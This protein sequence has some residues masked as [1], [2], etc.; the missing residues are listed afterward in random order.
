MG[1]V[2]RGPRGA[3][4]RCS[5]C[6]GPLVLV[7]WIPDRFMRDGCPEPWGNCCSC[8]SAWNL[9]STPARYPPDYYTAE[10]AHDT[11]ERHVARRLRQIAL[12]SLGYEHP[13]PR[14]LRARPARGVAHALLRHHATYGYRGFPTWN[15]PARALDVGCGNGGFLC[16]LRHQGWEA[17]GVEVEEG[18]RRALETAL[19]IRVVTPDAIDSME[20]GSFSHVRLSHSLEHVDEPLELLRRLRRLMSPGATLYVE[21][22]NPVSIQCRLCRDYWFA[23]ES[24]RHRFLPSPKGLREA[25]RSAGFRIERVWTL[26]DGHPWAWFYTYR[27]EEVGRMDRP[28]RPRLAIPEYLGAAWRELVSRLV[29][30]ARPDRDELVAAWA[31]A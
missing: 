8:G 27:R 1:I 28:F 20:A 17:I 9:G 25:L 29:C 10:L 26:H 19:G 22:P 23:W 3:I 4:R 14:W 5:L 21:A 31:R 24:P 7:E 13:L 2:T 6:D 30:L 18:H 11:S 12:Q 15:Q 16:A